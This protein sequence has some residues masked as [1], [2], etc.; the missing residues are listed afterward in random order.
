MSDSG[1]PASHLMIRIHVENQISS[2]RHTIMG[3]SQLSHGG[4]AIHMPTEYSFA[5]IVVLIYLF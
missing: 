2:S 5:L 1:G 3:I 4:S